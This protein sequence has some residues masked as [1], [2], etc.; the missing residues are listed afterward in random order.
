[1]ICLQ[2]N[3]NKQNILSTNRIKIIFAL[4]LCK[5]SKILSYPGFL[6]IGILIIFLDFA[7]IL[8]IAL[9]FLFLTF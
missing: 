7:R 6:L 5:I 4:Y 1:M 3:E 9:V 2:L 8:Q